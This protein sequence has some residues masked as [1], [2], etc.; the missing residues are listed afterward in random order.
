M[1]IEGK[2]KQNRWRNVSAVCLQGGRELREPLA[3]IIT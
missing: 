2:E 1:K 3:A